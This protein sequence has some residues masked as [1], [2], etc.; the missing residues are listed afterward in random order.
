MRI[1]R[2]NSKGDFDMSEVDEQQKVLTKAVSEYVERVIKNP[3]LKSDEMIAHAVALMQ[4][5][6]A[7]R[8]CLDS[9]RRFISGKPPMFMPLPASVA[10]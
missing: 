7:G 9:L 6:T 10:A 5:P 8:V 3:E 1:S 2:I 4:S